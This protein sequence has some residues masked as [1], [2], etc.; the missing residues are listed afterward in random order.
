M[1]NGRRRKGIDRERK[2]KQGIASESERDKWIGVTDSKGRGNGKNG[3][4][5]PLR[6][7]WS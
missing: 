3:R 7:K 2:G 1:K 4:E 5:E 6:K